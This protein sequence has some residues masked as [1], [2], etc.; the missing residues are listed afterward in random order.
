MSEVSFESKKLAPL[1]ILEVLEKYSDEYHILTQA[2]IAEKLD[3][4]YGIVLERKAVAR[5]I[6]LLEDAGFEFGTGKDGRGVYLLSRH[7]EEGELRMLI[8]SVAF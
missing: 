5:N 4:E 1:R 6:K 8:D 7:F 3:R 2:E